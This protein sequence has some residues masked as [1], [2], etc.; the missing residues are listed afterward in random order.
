MKTKKEHQGIVVPIIT[1]LTPDFKLDCRG[2]ENIF[3]HLYAHEVL[4]FIAG[5]T[6]EAA[7]LS[8]AFKHGFVKEAVKLKK[9]GT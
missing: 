8:L 3:S 7:S 2:L 9:P 1:P 4:P 5:T 6:G